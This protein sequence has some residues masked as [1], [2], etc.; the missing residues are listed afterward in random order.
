MIYPFFWSRCNIT[1]AVAA[2][3]ISASPSL[4]P[5]HQKLLLTSASEI[6]CDGCEEYRIVDKVTIFLS[7]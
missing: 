1:R 5:A 6:A 2:D 7:V 4:P 3:H